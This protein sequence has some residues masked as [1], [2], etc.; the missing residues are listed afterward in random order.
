[1][2]PPKLPW[3]V[4]VCILAGPAPSGSR[5]IC[6]PAPT[7]TDEDWIILVN[8]LRYVEAALEGGGWMNCLR[9]GLRADRYE[10]EANIATRSAWRK[11]DLNLIVTGSRDFYDAFCRATIL[12]KRLNVLDKGDRIAL[13]Q[14]VRH[15]ID[16]KS[17]VA[18][19]WWETV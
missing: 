16:G 10:M 14:A 6:D 17:P 19:R 12:A 5:Y 8:D 9:A 1:M 13:F 4:P 3:V 11:G 15:H 18:D 7:D 2:Q